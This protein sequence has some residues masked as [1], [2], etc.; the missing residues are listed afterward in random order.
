MNSLSQLSRRYLRRQWKRT[1]FTSLGIVMAT[2]L[3]AGLALLFTSFV[4]MY[5][6][7]E[8][9]GKGSWHYHISGLTMDQAEQLQANIR[10]KD[11]D[12]IASS[13]YLGRLVRG[14]ADGSESAG[15]PAEHQGDWLLLRDISQ[16]SDKMSPYPMSLL[17]G[18]MPENSSEI[19]LNT[20]TLGYFPGLEPGQQIELELIENGDVSNSQTLMKTYTVTGIADWRDTQLPGSAFYALT[21]LEESEK[22]LAEVYLTVKSSAGFEESVFAALGDVLPQVDLNHEDPLYDATVSRIKYVQY[23]GNSIKDDLSTIR[24]QTHDSLLRF[25]GQSSYDTT[26]R[27]L[28]RFFGILALIIMVSVIFVIRNSFAMSVSERTSEYGLLRVVGGSPSQ[29]RRLVL[30]DAVQ[31]AVVS[32]PAGLLAGIVAMK[33]TLGYVS[34]LGLPEIEY[35]KLI[36]SPWPLV[37][38]AALSILAIIL[39]A[40]S[41][42]VRAGRLSPMEAVRKSGVYTVKGK[43]RRVLTHG[44]K[45]SRRLTGVTGFLAGRSIRRDR[46]RFRITTLSVMISAILFLAAGGISFMFSEQ[47]SMFNTDQVDFRLSV[48]QSAGEEID[49]EFSMYQSLMTEQEGADRIAE[50]SQFYQTLKAEKSMFSAEMVEAVRNS[51]LINGNPVSEAE[52]LDMI[53][54]NFSSIRIVLSDRDLLDQLP[55]ADRDRVWSELQ[56]GKVIMS[57]TNPISVGDLSFQTVPMTILGVGDTV[58]VESSAFADLETGEIPD[59]PEAYHSY[60]IAAEIDELPWFTEGFFTGFNSIILF[61]DADVI[62]NYLE[63]SAEAGQITTIDNVV[64]VDAA[65]GQEAQIEK[66][67]QPLIEKNESGIITQTRIFNNF[68]ETRMSKN[69]VKGINVFVYGFATVIV[70]ICSMNILNTVTT[71]VLLRRRELGMLQAVGMSRSQVR[72]MLLI[73]SSLYGMNGAVWGS[74]IGTVLLYLLGASIG[75]TMG[76]LTIQSIPWNLVLATLA[77]ALI[78]SI[79]AGILPIRRVMKD[80][81][82]EAIRAQE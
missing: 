47:L 25:L 41:P 68:A 82:V 48:S 74:V 22:D 12:L 14:R 2:A 8:S 43:S 72:K 80:E 11:S 13:K 33:I 17:S 38:A 40:I 69:I 59:I 18:R 39:A 26:N 75:N 37:L 71:N 50:Y 76:G 6:E 1:V 58:K 64:A 65:E 62:M 36:V 49:Q 30:Q 34:R 10:V 66:L 28:V 5:I 31:M 54:N 19:V 63:R 42:A 24:M 32:I 23:S 60:E 52:A 45:L 3:F 55:L 9:A 56:S 70:L 51:T 67:L 4:N 46:R 27:E 81:V 77:G 44:G 15:V 20:T 78:I 29:I 79:A 7:S 57:Q 21:H 16:M 73:E 35:L 53:A 61:A